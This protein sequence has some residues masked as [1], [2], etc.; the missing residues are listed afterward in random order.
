MIQGRSKQG[1][2]IPQGPKGS[3]LRRFLDPPG[4]PG[5]PEMFSMFQASPTLPGNRC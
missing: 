4:V 5:P 2:D 3:L 1:F